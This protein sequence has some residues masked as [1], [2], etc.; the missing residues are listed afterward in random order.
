MSIFARMAEWSLTQVTP[1]LG[2]WSRTVNPRDG[3]YRASVDLPT[4]TWSVV[5]F[6]GDHGVVKGQEASLESA[7]QAADVALDQLMAEGH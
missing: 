1:N 4:F 5:N 7:Q 6:L 2:W 3:S